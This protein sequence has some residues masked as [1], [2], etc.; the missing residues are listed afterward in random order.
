MPITSPHSLQD[1]RKESIQVKKKKKRKEK[2]PCYD[3]PVKASSIPNL[4]LDP[5]LED[6]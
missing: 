4:D 6:C 3:V 1:Q 2:R 5:R